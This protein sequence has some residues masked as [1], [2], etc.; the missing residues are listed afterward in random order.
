VSAATKLGW[1][2]DTSTPGMPRTNAIA[3]SKVKLIVNGSRCL[4]LQAGLPSKFWPFA[5]QAFCNGVN[6]SEAGG[7]SAYFKRHGVEFHGKLIQ[8][9]CLVD[10]YPTKRTYR[11]SGKS[12]SSKRK[13]DDSDLEDSDGEDETGETDKLAVTKKFVEGV[14][15]QDT[16]LP[17]FSPR[18]IPGIFLGHRMAS[19]VYGRENTLCGIVLVFSIQTC[20]RF[21]LMLI[22]M[23]G[24]H[25]S[26]IC[27]CCRKTVSLSR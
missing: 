27:V 9:G 17:K 18:A 23:L 11:E 8:F 16:D 21:L 26:R 15:D 4:L 24:N 6:L 22:R 13:S 10:Y 12:K 7:V 25:M 14:D 20:A 19:G 1:T 3:E 2:Y 5:V